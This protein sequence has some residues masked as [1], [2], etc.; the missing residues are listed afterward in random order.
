[1]VAWLRGRVVTWSCVHAGDL[2]VKDLK[3]PKRKSHTFVNLAKPEIP[4]TTTM[5]SGFDKTKTRL[6]MTSDHDTKAYRS[7]SFDDTYYI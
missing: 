1:M 6:S 5:A 4:R 3:L 7:K 2:S